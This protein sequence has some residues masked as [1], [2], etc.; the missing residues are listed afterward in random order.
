MK[1]RGK[2]KGEEK[3]TINPIY[4]PINIFAMQGRTGRFEI[5]RAHGLPKDIAGVI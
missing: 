4:N 3:G 5:I 2:S 1:K